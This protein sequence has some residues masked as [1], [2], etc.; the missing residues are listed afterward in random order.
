MSRSQSGEEKD[1][2]LLFGVDVRYCSPNPTW[3]RFLS[4]NQEPNSE[5]KM[6][7]SAR[8]QRA[9]AK[10]GCGGD[11]GGDGGTDGG[12]DWGGGR[13]GGHRPVTSLKREW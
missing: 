2:R 1:N 3:R 6:A 10:L 5:F 8:K 12:A 11:G 7:A 13:W 9:A 4:T